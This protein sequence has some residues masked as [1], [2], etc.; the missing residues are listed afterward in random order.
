MISKSVTTIF[1][2][3]TSLIPIPVEINENIMW[4]IFSFVRFG[5]KILQKH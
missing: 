1:S 2:Y 4:W 5:M 3:V